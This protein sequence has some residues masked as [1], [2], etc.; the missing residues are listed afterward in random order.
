MYPTVDEVRQAITTAFPGA[1]VSNIHAEGR[2][3]LGSFVWP[4][5]REIDDPERNRLVTRRVRAKMGPRG[6]NL[7]VLVPLAP[8]E[9]L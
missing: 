6:F 1:D 7:G 2:R 4:E 8:G 9:T 3:V 5:F